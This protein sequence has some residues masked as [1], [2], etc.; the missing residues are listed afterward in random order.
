MNYNF[1]DENIIY[2]DRLIKLRKSIPITI[3]IHFIRNR[4]SD[5]NYHQVIQE[6]ACKNSNRNAFYL[7]IV[8]FVNPTAFKHFS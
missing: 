7:I 3:S 1:Q 8:F 4:E 6:I 5:F 2:N